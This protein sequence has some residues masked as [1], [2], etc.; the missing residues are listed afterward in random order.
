MSKSNTRLR[1]KEDVV[2]ES[3]VLLPEPKTREFRSPGD[4]TRQYGSSCGRD[5]VESFSMMQKPMSTTRL[6]VV[7]EE[8]GTATSK[9]Q[10][11]RKLPVCDN[12]GTGTTRRKS[13]AAL[14]I[15]LS[16]VK[17]VEEDEE[18]EGDDIRPSRG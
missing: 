6:L 8:E 11:R 12:A 13:L 3:I 2:D 10:D 16:H 4:L 15:R 5:P 17:V 9:S 18:E 14:M 7:P 1:A